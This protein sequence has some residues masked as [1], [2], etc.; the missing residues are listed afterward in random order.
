VRYGDLLNDDEENEDKELV[1]EMLA[2]RYEDENAEEGQIADDAKALF[3]YLEEKEIEEE[4]N[5]GPGATP[6]EGFSVCFCTFIIC[7]N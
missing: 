5:Q 1:D 2:K 7:N 4:I 6:A 3:A